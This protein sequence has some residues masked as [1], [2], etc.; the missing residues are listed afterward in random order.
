MLR[1]SPVYAQSACP[2]RRTAQDIPMTVFG[3]SVI[4]RTPG[5]GTGGGKSAM[6]QVDACMH[7]SHEPCVMSAQAIQTQ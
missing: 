4:S 1:L 6:L 2:H 5:R 3:L 7:D